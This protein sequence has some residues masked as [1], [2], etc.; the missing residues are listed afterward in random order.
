MNYFIKSKLLA[1][2]NASM[3]WRYLAYSAT[4]CT[5]WILAFWYYSNTFRTA[6][7]ICVQF[8]I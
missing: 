8:F 6:L 5:N 7:L 2:Y 4:V 3:F 1:L